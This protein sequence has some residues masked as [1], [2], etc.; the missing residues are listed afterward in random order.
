M[1]PKLVRNAIKCPDGTV[2]QSFTQH[3]YQS[4][5]DGITGETYMVDGGLVYQRGSINDVPAE[6]MS[7]WTD[8]PFHLVR[9]AFLWGTYGKYGDQPLQRRPL[10]TLTDNHIEAI[11]DTQFH[12]PEQYQELFK[13]ELEYR[14]HHNIIII[15]E[16]K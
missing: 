15:E 4:H 13:Q 12:V 1:N 10:S 9:D 7:L 11:L 14:K 6:N 8:S 3:D 5:V 16:S 2:L